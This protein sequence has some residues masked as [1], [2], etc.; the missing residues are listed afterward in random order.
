MSTNGAVEAKDAIIEMPQ[1]NITKEIADLLTDKVA[2][3]LVEVESDVWKAREEGDSLFGVYLGTVDSEFRKQG[4][5]E[6]V[7]WHVFATKSE[8]SGEP[9]IKRIL[10]QAVLDRVLQTAAVGKPVKLVFDGE[11]KSRNG[12]LNLYT[13]FMPKPA[14]KK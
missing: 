14:K 2:E 3:S 7:P 1:F 8:S 4:T 13:V 10:S 11:S 6:V 12:K 9:V 5:G